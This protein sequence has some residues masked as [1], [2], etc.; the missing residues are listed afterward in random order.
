[1]E[2]SHGLVALNFLL[3]GSVGGC[4]FWDEMYWYILSLKCTGTLSIFSAREKFS[5]DTET[6][7][8]SLLSLAVYFSWRY[9]LVDSIFWVC[10]WIAVSGKSKFV[11]SSVVS[12]ISRLLLCV[13]LNLSPLNTTTSSCL[14]IQALNRYQMSDTTCEYSLQHCKWYWLPMGRGE[15]NKMLCGA[16]AITIWNLS[17]VFM[18]ER[19]QWRVPLGLEHFFS[20]EKWCDTL[21]S[22][23]VSRRWLWLLKTDNSPPSLKYTYC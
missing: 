18:V 13:P 14:Q 12:V 1:M 20:S 11:G 8:G 9:I 3:R 10:C 23:F 19:T 15:A 21:A 4:W 2:E 22:H 17:T 5:S 16:N 6:V 7:V